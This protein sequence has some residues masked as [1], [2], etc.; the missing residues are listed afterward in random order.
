MDFSIQSSIV[1]IAVYAFERSKKFKAFSETR[2][3][4]QNMA[5]PLS[6]RKSSLDHRHHQR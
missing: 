3:F 5:C 1:V 4:K 2:E 6:D